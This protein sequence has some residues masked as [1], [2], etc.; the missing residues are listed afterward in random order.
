MG[1]PFSCSLTLT[2]GPSTAR[3]A[4][5]D[6]FIE[7]ASIATHG[8][9]SSLQIFV[10]LGEAEAQDI[11]TAA[12]GEEC[13]A[14]YCGYAGLREQSA[15]FFACVCSGDCA[16]VCQHVVSALRDRG[17]EACVLQCGAEHVALGLVFGCQRR[18]EA[19]GEFYQSGDGAVLKWRGRADVGEV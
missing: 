6:N 15:G 13:G 16:D 2:A 1:N 19:V 14:G 9:A 17:R 7:S 10:A 12:S 8:F 18:I 5:D 4:Q 11:F 3:C